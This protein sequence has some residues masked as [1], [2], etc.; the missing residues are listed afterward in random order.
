MLRQELVP[1]LELAQGL[2]WGQMLLL[3]VVLLVTSSQ[4]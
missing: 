1:E 2:V 3:L 4:L